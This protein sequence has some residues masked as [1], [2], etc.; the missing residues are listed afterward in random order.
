MPDCALCVVGCLTNCCAFV[1]VRCVCA[2]RPPLPPSH[3]TVLMY[4]NQVSEG[5]CTR[6]KRLDLEV[7]PRS[8]RAHTRTAHMH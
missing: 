4:L 2:C 8:S 5:G 6:F 7:K 1:T 3:Q